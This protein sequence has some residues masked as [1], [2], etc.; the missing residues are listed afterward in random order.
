MVF[1]VIGTP[2]QTFSGHLTGGPGRASPGPALSSGAPPHAIFLAPSA[3]RAA[4]AVGNRQD[5]SDSGANALPSL[6]A[7]ASG[8]R[9]GQWLTFPSTHQSAVKLASHQ[10]RAA[11]W[12]RCI[13]CR[14]PDE[15]CPRPAIPTCLHG[16]V[17]TKP[18]SRAP[19]AGNDRCRHS[20]ALAAKVRI[21][22]NYATCR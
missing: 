15:S 18:C 4:L 10:L 13:R 7:L 17:H 3:P 19:F 12:H 14:S 11:L 6:V 5:L 1:S 8:V 21:R 22:Q 16:I 2:L 20:Q 9:R